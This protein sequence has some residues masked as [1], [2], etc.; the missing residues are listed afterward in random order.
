MQMIFLRLSRTVDTNEISFCVDGDEQDKNALSLLD[1]IVA[2]HVFSKS[3]DLE[4][5][6]Y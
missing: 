5:L 6:L 1:F 3:I 2:I 4:R